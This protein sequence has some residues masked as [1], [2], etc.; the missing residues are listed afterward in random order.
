MIDWADFLSCDRGLLIA[1]AGHG[2][3]TAIADCLLQCP[4]ESCVLVLTHTHAGIASLLNKFRSKNIPSKCYKIETITGF[5]QRYVLNFY[6]KSELPNEE[7]KH[8]FYKVVTKCISLLEHKVIQS[9]VMSS[10]N[11]VFVDEYQ[12]CT[13][14]QH[15]MIMSLAKNL[16]LHLF[17]DPM[18]GVFSFD[19]MQLVDLEKDLK[20]FR[21]FNTLNYPWRWDK[22]NPEL[23]KFILD[24]RRKLETIEPVD[25]TN[26]QVHGL[27]TK[28]YTTDEEGYRFLVSQIR[29]TNSDSMLII[30]PSYRENGKYGNVRLRGDLNDRIKLKQRIDFTHTFTI[31]DAIDSANYYTYA[32][33]IDEFIAKSKDKRIK[34]ISWLYDILIGLHLSKTEINKWIHREGD[35]FIKRKKEYACHYS[36]LT[37]LFDIYKS[38]PSTKTLKPLIIYIHGL[39]GVKCYHGEFYR[40]I[41]HCMDSAILNNSSVY[42]SMKSTK[43]KLRHQGRK[44]KGKCIGTT[45]LTK[46]LE[47]DTVVIWEAHKFED[48][49]NFY[50]AISRAC[51]KLIILSME[52]QIRFN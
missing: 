30:C 44:I 34:R 35:R 22:T 37:E 23:G 29:Q 3:T 26:H 38:A 33:K 10:Y 48:A 32:R 45:L 43:D 51:S 2:K 11:R 40:T 4:K 16:P 12:D 47:F 18:Q 14:E 49:K 6:G 19:N 8:Y 9:I 24:T 41:L 27:F 20:N 28:I 5:A 25:L 17:G 46:G 50:V 1:P 7:D 42:D 36:K 15:L 31:I 21:R 52:P 13:K 39:S